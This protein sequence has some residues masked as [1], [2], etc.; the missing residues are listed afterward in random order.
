MSL[1][2]KKVEYPFN[3]ELNVNAGFYRFFFFYILHYD[4]MLKILYVKQKNGVKNLW[5]YFCS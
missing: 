2:P 1:F 4:N 5:T 3:V